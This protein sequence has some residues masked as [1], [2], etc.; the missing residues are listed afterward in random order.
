ML[1][2]A[3]RVGRWCCAV[4]PASARR[5]CWIIRSSERRGFVWRGRLGCSRRWSFL[6]LGCI[7]CARRCWIGSRVFQILSGM[8]SARRSASLLAVRLISSLS[9]WRCSVYFRRWLRSARCCVSSTM[10]SGSTG[11]RRGCWR[12]SRGDWAKRRSRLFSRSA[13]LARSSSGSLSC[14]S[15]VSAMARHGGCWARW[16]GWPLDERVRDRIVAETHG[17]PLA[18]LEL[19]CGLKPGE[20]VGGFWLPVALPLS[21]RIEESFRRR[22]EQLPTD[23]QRLLLVAAAEPVGDPV[24]LWRAVER[25]G[26]STAAGGSRGGGR[27]AR[28]RHPGAVSSSAGALCRLSVR[29]TR[30]TSRGA[31]GARGGHRSAT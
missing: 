1:F 15:R 25:L 6:S 27:A 2:A 8:R 22:L 16:R 3:V 11:R 24:L 29:D 5:R 13:S 26:L 7:S 20:P 21:G 30:G 31:P 10:R 17:N 9:G 14:S 12:S 19:P 18:L 28:D 4:K 23:T